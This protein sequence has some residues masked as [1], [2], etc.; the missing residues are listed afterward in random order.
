MNRKMMPATAGAMPYGHSSSVRYTPRPRIFCVASPAA[1]SA[2]PTDEHGHASREHERRHDA[3]VVLGIGEELGEV[4][5]PDEGHP[6]AERRHPE[7]A[8]LERL[9]RGP[10]EEDD[11]DRHLREDQQIRQPPVLEDCSLHRSR[12]T[13]SRH[14]AAYCLFCAA[15]S[16]SISLLFATASSSPCLAVFL[17]R[18]DVL[19]LALDHVADLDEVAQPDPLAVRRWPSRSGLAGAGFFPASAAGGASGRPVSSANAV[20]W[21]GFRTKW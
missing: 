6:V 5:E 13:R 21:S 12:A 7:Q 4:V 17:P 8:E 2:R 15:N 14:R 18:E 11:G 10:E 1:T 16:F 20:Y 19:H 9:E 3:R